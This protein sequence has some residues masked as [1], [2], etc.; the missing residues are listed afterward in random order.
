MQ[1]NWLLMKKP[2]YLTVS[3][4][5]GDPNGLRVVE[6][7]GWYGMAVAFPRA[8]LQNMIGLRDEFSKCAVYILLG[9]SEDGLG[10]VIYIG[11]A[12]PIGDRLLNHHANKDFWNRALFFTGSGDQINKTHVQYLETKLLQ[13]ASQAKRC[14]IE[15]RNN[16]TLPTISEVERIRAEDFLEHVLDICPLLGVSAFEAPR[17]DHA[18]ASL[19]TNL[20]PKPADRQ[21][22]SSKPTENKLEMSFSNIVA[23]GVDSSSG[24]IVYAGSMAVSEPVPSML[25]G[26]PAYFRLREGLIANGVLVERNGHYEFAQD[27][28]FD[29][30]SAAAAIIRGRS[31]NGRIEWKTVDGVT[32][33][34]LQQRSLKR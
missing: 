25:T 4:V 11:Q 14:R 28:P 10:E 13:L 21:S 2:F 26:V 19:D 7:S 1:V 18:D 34:E 16:P 8:V 29:S 20:R 15:N 12:D 17:I 3:V 32:L 33:K 24:F 6:H 30:P 27:Y 22:R 23:T 9:P 5:T 31:A